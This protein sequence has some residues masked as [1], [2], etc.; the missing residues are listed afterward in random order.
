MRWQRGAQAIIAIFVIGFVVVLVMTLRQERVTPSQDP[1]PA[2]MDKEATVET[3]GGIDTRH[4]DASGRVVFALKAMKHLRYPDGR[5][6][7]SDNVEITTSR[8]DKN[9]VVKADHGELMPEGNDLKWGRFRGHVGLTTDGGVTVEA[10]EAH[11]TKENG[12]V[13]IPG[14]MTFTKG[15]MRGSG[16]GATYDQNR[17]VLWILDQAT[18]AVAPGTD[19]LGGLDATAAKIGLAQADHYITL[20]GAGR[21]EG[22]GRVTHADVITVRLDEDGERVRMLELRGHSGITG[23]QGGP[24]AMSASDI[25][26]TYAEDGRTLQVA[27]LVQ[28]AVL[29]LPG[30]GGAGRRIAG[31]AIDLALAPDGATVTNLTANERVQVDLPADAQT[32]AKRIRAA[33]L[34]AVGAPGRGLEKATFAGG[35]DYE[36][37]RPAGRGVAAVNRTARSLKLLIETKP[38][39]GALEKADFRGNVVFNDAPEFKGEA[40]QG[41]YHIAGDRLE[42]MPADGEPG[43]SARVTDGRMSVQARTIGLTLSTHEMTADTRVRSTILAQKSPGTRGAEARIPSMLAQDQEVNVTSNRL[44]YKNTSATYSGNVTLWQG[45]TRIKAPTIVIDEKSGNLTASEGVAT[46]FLFDDVDS[47]TGVRTSTES[48]GKADTFAYD[49]AKRLATYTGKA[50]I[51]GGLGN[52][53]GDRIL[54]FMKASQNELERTEAFGANGSVVVREG[55]RIANGDHLTYTAVDDTYVMTGILVEVVEE[56]EGTCTKT[57][58]RSVRFS[59]SS[60]TAQFEGTE[61]FPHTART[62]PCPPELTRK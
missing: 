25:D 10:G 23:G 54:L 35:V 62:L 44:Q 45:K 50:Q 46:V 52:L 48:T 18:I 55:A 28:N 20:D 38:G 6:V 58:A 37:T 7:V 24:Q 12:M 60:E 19:G 42:L 3:P 2:R 4:T 5:N 43:P 22:E 61:I 30:E 49:D 15:R 39:L 41:V 13:T 57:Q 16:V 56:K 26:L 47:K 51:Q 21:I 27:R 14:P 33:T 36:E 59:R 1:P 8:H 31:N 9:L 29:Q 32:P 40:A 11:Y 34:V 53:A 17:E